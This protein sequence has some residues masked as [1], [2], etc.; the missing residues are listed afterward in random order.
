MFKPTSILKSVVLKPGYVDRVC[1]RKLIKDLGFLGGYTWEACARLLGKVWK[2]FRRCFAR[3][4]EVQKPNYKRV[5]SMP[6]AC[7]TLFKD[8][9]IWGGQ[10][11]GRN[12]QFKEIAYL[13]YRRGPRVGMPYE[14]A[15]PVQSPS[16][17]KPIRM[18]VKPI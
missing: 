14:V 12:E 4:S 15:L 3:L 13:Q 16:N 2:R 9:V 10:N 8:Q 7:D 17:M 18:H 1:W 5:N 11:V 6:K